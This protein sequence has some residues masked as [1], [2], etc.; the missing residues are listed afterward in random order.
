MDRSSTEVTHPFIKGGEVDPI[1]YNFYSC[2]IQSP[3]V[4]K[5]QAS[6]DVWIELVEAL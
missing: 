6:G 2:A 4:A 3:S 5:M 1:G